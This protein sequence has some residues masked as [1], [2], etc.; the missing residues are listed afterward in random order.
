MKKSS[1][2]PEISFMLDVSKLEPGLFVDLELGWTEHP[3]LF[4]RFIIKTAN[5]VSVIQSLGLKKVKVIPGQCTTKVS[6][7]GVSTEV[8]DDPSKDLWLA[9]QEKLEQ[10]RQYRHQRGAVAS[11]Y[12]AS[13]EQIKKLNQSLKQTPEQAIDEVNRVVDEVVETVIVSG[14]V[15][16]SIVNL[17]DDQ[18]STHNHAM[19]VLVLSL[20]IGRVIG[21]PRDKMKELGLG[22]LLHDI[23]KSLIPDKVLK[24]A[25]ELTKSEVNYLQ[26][27]TSL[28]AD[29]ARKTNR[30]SPE[31]VDIIAQH[32]EML[33]G[34]GYP[35]GLKGERIP[36]SSRIVAITNLYDNFCNP[37]DYRLAQTPKDTLADLFR[38]YKNRLDGDLIQSFVT[39]MGIFPPGTIIR[40]SDE[41][42][43]LVVTVCAKTLLNPQILLYNP[44]IPK[45]EAVLIDLAQHQ[46]LKIAKA[47]K[48][49]DCPKEIIEYLGIQERVGYS[50]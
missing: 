34:S 40:L 36:V 28:G 47:V 14:D 44:E 11:R 25:G 46:E 49:V 48:Q 50:I 10:A 31:V 32:H 33:D 9:K 20:L 21:L 24:K 42:I 2:K 27:H 30:L 18:F 45:N 6:P 5:E 16:V 38:H 41:S 3:F 37:A 43:G 8:Q 29:I 39:V 7:D 23:G 22:A 12:K 19:N 15:L 1:K 26:T 13:V 17:P 35:N 4:S